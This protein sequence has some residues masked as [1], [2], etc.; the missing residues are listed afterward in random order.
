[1]QAPRRPQQNQLAKA[2]GGGGTDM[3]S[4]ADREMPG[5]FGMLAVPAWA[6]YNRTRRG[7]SPS[8]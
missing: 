1:M 5:V 7:A 4:F 8:K 3:I 2:K 6:G